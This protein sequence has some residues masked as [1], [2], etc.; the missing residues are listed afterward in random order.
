MSDI[1]NVSLYTDFNKQRH[2]AHKAKTENIRQ[3]KLKSR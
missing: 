3:I 1:V 2:N